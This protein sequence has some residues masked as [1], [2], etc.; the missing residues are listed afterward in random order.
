MDSGLDYWWY[1][2]NWHGIIPGILDDQIDNKAWGQYI[3]R[4]VTER[5]NQE[6]GRNVRLMQMG[7]EVSKHPANHRY[8][9]WWTGDIWTPELWSNVKHEVNYG[10]N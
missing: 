4:S 5:Y 9:V 10:V 6:H 8:P 7:R 2:T 1:D 3:F